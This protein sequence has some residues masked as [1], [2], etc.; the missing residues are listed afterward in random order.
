M[1]GTPRMRTERS[2]R[3]SMDLSV[4]TSAPPSSSSSCVGNAMRRRMTSTSAFLSDTITLTL[5]SNSVRTRS[6]SAFM[7]TWLLSTMAAD[8]TK[9]ST[10]GDWWRRSSSSTSATDVCT[11][12]LSS[13]TT[14]VLGSGS[15]Q[16]ADDSASWRSVMYCRSEMTR[17]TADWSTATSSRRCT[18]S[19]GAL[20][21]LATLM[22]SR[23]RGTPRVTF[24]LLTPAKWNVLSVICV[25][26]SPMLCAATMP[27]ISPACARDSW[28]RVRTSP[29]S[30][31]KA[32]CDSRY[33][34][35]T[36]LLASVLRSMIENSSVASCCASTL[37]GSAPGTT[38]SSAC[39]RRT[40]STTS[41]GPMS[42][43]WLRS[44]RNCFCA[45]RTSR[46]R[47]T[48][49]CSCVPS[50]PWLEAAMMTRRSSRSASS[51]SSSDSSS[52]ISFWSV[53]IC[54]ITSGDR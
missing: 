54:A 53:R 45:L 34:R 11:S 9:R 42:D 25:T 17:F 33:R 51:C 37:M 52:S 31:S 6:A 10:H 35:S 15:H 40:P 32:S 50:S 23:S 1:P 12:S 5:P 24:L 47:L 20:T 38:S 7:S 36:C 29:S 44:S 46:P 30:H 27:H 22:I 41:P 26:H 18:T 19:D 21:V 48:G 3:S 14:V 43:G 16:M 39:S 8:S 49:T 4:S 13:S 28:N 2:R